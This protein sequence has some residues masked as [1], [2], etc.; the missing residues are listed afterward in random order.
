VVRPEVAQTAY[1][2]YANVWEDVPYVRAD[3]VQAILDVQPRES[4]KGI[5]PDK[6]IDNSLIKV[7]EDTGFI[8]E[9]HGK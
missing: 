2:S 3:S 7:L 9:L 8:K 1:R 4:V 5:T 6:F